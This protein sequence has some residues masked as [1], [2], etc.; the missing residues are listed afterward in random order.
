MTIIK[1]QRN[2]VKTFYFNIEQCLK[3]DEKLSFDVVYALNKTKH[4]I[5][6]IVEEIGDTINDVQKQ[7]V[8]ITMDFCEKD[9]NGKPVIVDG[10]YSGL[11]KGLNVEYDKKIE[12]ITEKQLNYMREEVEIEIHMLNIE[13][14]PKSGPASL[15]NILCYFVE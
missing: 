5:K 10:Q 1:M 12:D 11:S 9:E 3:S 2:E 4:K 14:L 7:V 13:N 15:I 6:S 8:N